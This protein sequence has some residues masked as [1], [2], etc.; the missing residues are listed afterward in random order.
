MSS[1]PKISIVTPS[2]NQGQFLEDTI[3]SVVNQNYPNLEYIIID[4]GST[5]GS[6]EIIK[7]YEK[8]LAYWVS[9]PDKGH[10][11]A[12]NK[13]F[14]R[15][16]GEIMAWINSDD[17]YYPYTF[18]TIAE[19]FNSFR[20][21]NWIQGKNS[22]VD[23][24][25]R[26]L[27]VQF[28]YIN[29][30]SYL[31]GEYKWIQQES[32]FWRRS[33]WERSGA[34][35]SEKLELMFD[36]ELWTRFFLVDDLWHLDLVISCFRIHEKN[37]SYLQIDKVYQEMND[38][39]KIMKTN[40][41]SRVSDSFLDLQNYLDRINNKKQA[42][43]AFSKIKIF[44]FLPYFL[45]NKFMRHKISKEVLPTLDEKIYEFK[46]L[47]HKNDSWLKSSQKFKFLEHE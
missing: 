9:E 40:L 14:A 39:I 8:Y 41:S 28:S 36:G 35:I 38:V 23:L 15:S 11:H 19:I 7:K 30:F 13:G 34:H 4:G 18:N 32:V 3:L 12:L 6:V 31:L 17:K 1:L 16:T 25:G 20:D 43:I 26:L 5:D 2:F 42:Q 37:R 24:S 45:Y 47:N 46:L 44:K 27:D 29:I 22:W 10:G 21:I 33:L